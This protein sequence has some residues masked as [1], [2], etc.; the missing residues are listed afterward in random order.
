MIVWLMNSP[1]S[2]PLLRHNLLLIFSFWLNAINVGDVVVVIFSRLLLLL[3]ITSTHSSVSA[4]S[5]S[6]G[7]LGHSCKPVLINSS[8]HIQ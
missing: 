8:S 1:F 4:S 2:I 5:S 7:C 6:C 3:V